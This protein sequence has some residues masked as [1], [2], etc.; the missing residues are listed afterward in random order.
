MLHEIFFAPFKQA[1][2]F[3]SPEVAL[4]PFVGGSTHAVMTP[5]WTPGSWLL[6]AAAIAATVANKTTTTACGRAFSRRSGFPRHF[7]K[8]PFVLAGGADDP[9][10]GS[11]ST[12]L[13]RRVA[14]S[15]SSARSIAVDVL[16]GNRPPNPP[17][18]ASRSCRSDHPTKPPLWPAGARASSRLGRSAESRGPTRPASRRASP[19]SRSK[20]KNRWAVTEIEPPTPWV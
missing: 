13:V 19:C 2:K 8:L 14:D 4:L 6:P 10:L 3:R 16:V 1:R 20:P 18:A 5:L 7:Q 12:K 15:T 9:P 11:A 17:A